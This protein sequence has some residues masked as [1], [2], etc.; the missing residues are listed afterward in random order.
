MG[1]LLATLITPHLKDQ[2][3]PIDLL[4]PMP[5]SA[6]RMKS[7]GYNQAAVITSHVAELT[8]WPYV[9][10]ALKK[11]KDTESQVHLTVDERMANL[12]GAFEAE[13]YLV[14]GKRVLILDDVFTTG[15]TMRQ[16]TKALKS[17]GAEKIFAVT[18]ARTL[19]IH[20]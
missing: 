10:K 11:I 13:P 14:S 15:A 17:A 20:E 12:D 3:D 16:A 19:L 4:I 6:E 18:I 1:R 7:R 5:L 2:F 8:S 9:P